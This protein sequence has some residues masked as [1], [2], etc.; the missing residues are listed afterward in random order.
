MAGWI[1][2]KGPV[3]ADTFYRNGKL[4][5]REVTIK[6]PAVTFPTNDYDAPGGVITLPMPRV[7]AME[8][9]IG[10]KGL[11]AELAA[12]LPLESAKYEARWVQNVVDEEG[13]SKPEGCK[14][15]LRCVPKG[16][17]GIELTPGN[18]SE[19]E[20]ALA[21]IRYELFVAGKE[22]WCVAPLVPMSFCSLFH[23]QHR[24]LAQ[25]STFRCIRSRQPTR[26]F[27]RYR[28]P[29]PVNPKSWPP[30]P[31]HRSFPCRRLPL[32]SYPGFLLSDLHQNLSHL[33][34]R[35]RPVSLAADHHDGRK[36]ATAEAG[37]VVVG[38]Q[39]V[40][41]DF[42]LVYTKFLLYDFLDRRRP[43]DMARRP[44]AEQNQ[45]FTHRRRAELRVERHHAKHLRGLHAG[46]CRDVR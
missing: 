2:L 10:K 21:V 6:L 8:A 35:E 45:V 43:V 31:R 9:S 30:P 42:A 4:V 18:V 40:G 29:A 27:S 33:I 36:A 13:I 17:P 32:Y 41:G 3:L 38:K 15:F 16:A 25:D 14:A 12:I 39:S 24:R 46:S 20:I 37:H 26:Q 28:F 34:R 1:D 22:Y 7:Q 23:R 5:G 11:D 19:S 44:L